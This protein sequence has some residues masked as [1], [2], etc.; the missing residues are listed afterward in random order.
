ML[1]DKHRHTYLQHLSLNSC[2]GILNPFADF[3]MSALPDR[4]VVLASFEVGGSRVYI[5]FVEDGMNGHDEKVPEGGDDS[6]IV[7]QG[8]GFL[9]AGYFRWALLRLVT[10]ALLAKHTVRCEIG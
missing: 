2:H 9:H 1:C 8:W 6:I 5:P 3:R 7:V 4:V 10:H